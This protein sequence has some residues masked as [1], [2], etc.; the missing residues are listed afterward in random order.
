MHR[1]RQSRAPQATSLCTPGGN[2]VHPR[3]QPCSS[4][5]GQPLELFRHRRSTTRL[6]H[7]LDAGAAARRGVGD[8]AGCCVFFCK[9]CNFQADLHV[10]TT[11]ER[12][13]CYT[14]I[15]TYTH[16]SRLHTCPPPSLLASSRIRRVRST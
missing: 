4:Q 8:N 6:L 1:R 14:R 9:Q 10:L 11:C 15:A 2:P 3:R 16:T 5:V 12:R 13:T 7:Q